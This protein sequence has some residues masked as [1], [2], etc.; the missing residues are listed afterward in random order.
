MKWI[1]LFAEM[2]ASYFSVTP[3]FKQVKT[4]QLVQLFIFPEVW[5]VEA[6]VYFSAGWFYWRIMIMYSLVSTVRKRSHEILFNL[7][8]SPRND[9][10]DPFP[11][12]SLPGYCR[13]RFMTALELLL[14]LSTTDKEISWCLKNCKVKMV[15]IVERKWFQGEEK[16][17]IFEGIRTVFW[18]FT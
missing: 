8:K 11:S 1:E 4:A 3:E 14:H 16:M 17:F 15:K 7:Q 18:E 9:F 2:Y 10:Q 5:R 12:A 6:S 13:W